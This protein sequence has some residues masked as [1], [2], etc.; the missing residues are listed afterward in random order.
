MSKENDRRKQAQQ[1]WDFS[2]LTNSE[3]TLKNVIVYESAEFYPEN[4]RSVAD[5][6]S[7]NYPLLWK[8]Q[9][10]GYNALHIITHLYDNTDT[11]MLNTVLS[12][13][14]HNHYELLLS[15]KEKHGLTPAVYAARLG[16]WEHVLSFAKLVPFHEND[17]YDFCGALDEAI[18]YGKVDVVE[19]LLSDKNKPLFDL[20]TKKYKQTCFHAAI[21]AN[22]PLVLEKL[23]ELGH[24]SDEHDKRGETPFQK[25]FGD[26][27][28]NCLDVL[29]KD[30][31]AFAAID[32]HY[33]IHGAAIH[34]KAKTIEK[35]LS[36]GLSHDY[37]YKGYTALELA[38]MDGSIEC[39]KLLLDDK[40]LATFC[41]DIVVNQ[42]GE[43]SWFFRRYAM[44]FLYQLY[45]QPESTSTNE[46]RLSAAL[47]LID[48][49]NDKKAPG[50]HW[51]S[52][53]ASKAKVI[54]LEVK[55]FLETT[56][57]NQIKSS[58]VESLSSISGNDS[59][60]SSNAASIDLTEAQFST[61][62]KALF[63]ASDLRLINALKSLNFVVC[64]AQTAQSELINFK[65]L[66]DLAAQ[67]P[68]LISVGTENKVATENLNTATQHFNN[69]C[70]NFSKQIDLIL[71][72]YQAVEQLTSALNIQLS[73]D[74]QTS[75]NSAINAY[76]SFC[77]TYKELC[78]FQNMQLGM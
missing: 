45:N 6:L 48:I 74:Q 1:N 77:N 27:K 43:H 46:E 33:Y 52:S 67:N 53:Q 21:E 76:D 60:I 36:C 68:Y 5:M 56:E 16:K 29:I 38:I 63:E 18:R 51:F 32:K 75:M 69:S 62:N 17:R 11:K 57:V 25:A 39:A 41:K 8:V 66:M 61:S 37:K 13:T 65:N 42:S 44:S 19:A 55:K 31:T 73:F 47:A 34:S 40:S 14:T 24:N 78:K 64:S 20:F 22:Q 59:L 7:R 54:E 2:R 10:T 12:A 70:A 9:N 28:Q 15:H 35:L 30:P 3:T 50:F 72:T 4:T 49:Y 58:Y 23:L 71:T 26:G